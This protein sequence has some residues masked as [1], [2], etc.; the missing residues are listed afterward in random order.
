M[1]DLNAVEI[2]QQSHVKL[3]MSTGV[4]VGDLLTLRGRLPRCGPYVGIV[5]D[6]FVVIECISSELPEPRDLLS[7]RIADRMVETYEAVG[8]QSHDQKRFRAE[9]RAKFWGASLDGSAG[10][11]RMQL[12]KTVPIAMITSQVARLGVANRK[13]L[14]V[15]C[16]SWVAILQCR[17]RAMCLLETAFKDI[18]DYDYGVT[19]ELSPTTVDELWSLVILA[20]L[21]AT[22]LRAEVCPELSLVDAS[23]EWE[24]EVTTLLEPLL[25][26]E[27]HRQKLTKAAWSRLLS[28]LKARQRLHKQLDPE[29]EVPDGE[30]PARS[31]PLWTTTI[32]SKQFSLQWRRRTRRRAHINVSE[33]SAALRAEMRRARKFPNRRLLLGSDSQVSLG[34]L[35]KGRSASRSLNKLLRQALPTLLCYNVYTSLQYVPTA[36]NV[37]DDPTRNHLCRQ[38]SMSAPDWLTDICTG[39][40]AGFDSKLLEDGLDDAHIAR[41][42]CT[43]VEP[44]LQPAGGPEAGDDRALPSSAVPRKILRPG[45]NKSCRK[46]PVAATPVF[47]PWM[48]RRRLDPTVSSLLQ[49]IPCNQFVLPRGRSFDQVITKPGHLD[50]FSGSRIAAQELANRTGHW[51]LTYDILHSPSEDL[52]DP[53]VQSTIEKMLVAGC[54]LSLTAG[55]VCA[56]FSRAVRPMV[57]SAQFPEGLT[58]IS[59]NMETKVKLGNAMAAWLAELV[60]KVLQLH[61]PFWIENP[62]GSFLWLQP[63]WVD[64]VRQVQSFTTD[65]CRWGTPWRKRTKFLGAFAAAG[66]KCLCI[67]KR[68]HQRLVGYSSTFKCSWTKAAEPYPRS[69]ARFLAAAIA[70][71]LKPASRR[72]DLDP[73]SC[74]RCGHRRIGEAANPGPRQRTHQPDIDLEQVSLVQPATVALQAKIHRLFL[75]WLQSELSAGAFRSLAATPALQVMFLRSFGN[76]W[77]Q[78]GRPMY[79]FRHLV[80]FCQQQF[81][82]ERHHTVTA[83][84]LLAKWET[85]Q[86]TKHRPPLPKVIL[87]AFTCLSL[88][89]GWCR[90]AAITL[91]AF[92]GACRVGEP[93]KALRRDLILPTDAGLEGEDI[94]FLN[95][96]A[97]KPGRRG[98]GRVQ[99]T[100]VTDRATVELAVAVFS[101]LRPSE[102]L[103]P[104]GLSSYRRRWN[105]LIEV[106]EIPLSASLTPGCTRGGGAVYLYHKG[107]PI[108]NIQWTMRVKQ[109]STLESYLQE[110]A[111][112]AVMQ[113]MAPPTREKIQSCAKMMPHIMRLWTSNAVT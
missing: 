63:S 24:A 71:D 90:F 23:G 91:L 54:F 89:W 92:H 34:A 76:W 102:P 78:Q 65:Y 11:L 72:R 53:A 40:Y 15:L 46:N 32:K 94:C 113:K 107:T 37:A 96:P 52:L 105:K 59:S 9:T 51:V 111:A 110:T 13:L 66:K 106:L 87:D 74:A 56:S 81:P 43:D 10:T 57:R 33:L 16:G 93:L 38:P 18:Q 5:I 30:Q 17:R 77:F 88:S 36:D 97:P 6:D 108:S 82:G 98:R 61:L 26:G 100:K 45:G 73:S 27:L 49:E 67:C 69:L 39:D 109:Q 50:L 64:L 41:L 112:L 95:I 85:I 44:A 21:F 3:A 68:R 101:A 75:N 62:A 28:P 84:E 42:P 14:E 79:L 7:S 2:G 1:G 80:V 48:P 31:H 60:K 83:W 4:R 55:P 99:H 20:P 19:F 58:G 25:A 29:L 86:P 47:E 22:D 35:V 12:E 104:S 8:L 70:E 103:Y